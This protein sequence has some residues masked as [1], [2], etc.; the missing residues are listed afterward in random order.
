MIDTILNMQDGNAIVL[1]DL[2]Q[3]AV[4]KINEVD[5]DH[6]HRV[7]ITFQGDER[8]LSVGLDRLN[9][10]LDETS[11][12]GLNSVLS[13]NGH[14]P[15]ENIGFK[16]GKTP[17]F[18]ELTR[19]YVKDINCLPDEDVIRFFDEHDGRVEPKLVRQFF[20][21]GIWYAIKHMDNISIELPPE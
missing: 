5:S 13:T 9:F 8:K 6:A 14:W 10:S 15:I 18:H 16:N 7:T 1:M 21:L 12:R 11:Y 19:E 2:L 17:P 4:R 20:Y 3:Q